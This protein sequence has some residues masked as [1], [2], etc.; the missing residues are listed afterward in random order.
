VAVHTYRLQD[1][2]FTLGGRRITGA[3]DG[4]KISFAPNSE[5]FSLTVGSEGEAT[6]SALNNRS[7]RF[8]LTLQYGAS[9]NSFL[10]DL[11]TQDRLTG[12]NVVPLSLVDLRNRQDGGTGTEMS[13][14]EAWVVGPP[15]FSLG[16]EVG[17][18]EWVI[19]AAQI[20]GAPGGQAFTTPP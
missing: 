7:G 6:R 12:D 5:S 13:A 16:R 18:V 10:N 19:E 9:D 4:D 14:P 11:H 17:T 15:S 3:G 1:I 8:T 20:S 2:I